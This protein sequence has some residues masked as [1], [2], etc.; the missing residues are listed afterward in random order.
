MS[1][2]PRNA[3]LLWLLVAPLAQPASVTVRVPVNP[4]ETLDEVVVEAT[5]ARLSQMRQEMVQLEDRFFERFNELNTIDDFDTYCDQEARIGTQ[6]KRRYCRAVYETKALRTEGQEYIKHLPSFV[7]P[8]PTL[9]APPV[10]AIVV[11][12]ARRKDYQKNMLEVTS[13]NPELIQLARERYELGLRYEA[14]RRKVFGKKPPPEE[15]EPSPAPPI[16]PQ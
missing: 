3:V 9:S 7:D 1:R 15:V 14:T 2:I 6:M 10:P 4:E 12:E 5:R 11:I 13:R 16:T 8:T